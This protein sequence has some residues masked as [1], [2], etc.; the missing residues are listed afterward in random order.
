MN[1]YDRM[2]VEAIKQARTIKLITDEGTDSEVVVNILP[3]NKDLR[4]IAHDIGL[5]IQSH[6][7]RLTK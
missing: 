3:G 1:S 6:Y 4:Y 5:A 7:N 2:I